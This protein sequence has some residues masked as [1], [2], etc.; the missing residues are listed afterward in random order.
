VESLP[1]KCAVGVFTFT[2]NS[3]AEA[4]TCAQNQFPAGSFVLGSGG[5][6]FSY[7]VYCPDGLGGCHPCRQYT[8]VIALTASDAQSCVQSQNGGCTVVNSCQSCAAGLT[9]CCGTCKNLND[10]QSCGSCTN[11]CGSGQVCCSGT[12]ADLK[13]DPK[14]CGG[15]GQLCDAAWLSCQNGTCGCASGY[16]NCGSGFCMPSGSTCCDP[17]KGTYCAQGES[18][19]SGSCMPSGNVCCGTYNCPGGTACCGGGC[20]PA[21]TACCGTYYCPTGVCCT[22]SSTGCC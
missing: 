8:N 7:A 14:N 12:C 2:A 20:I 11:A 4:T 1:S 19:C 21:G 10:A 3:L 5:G 13:T 6:N 16:T 17:A 9:D 18:C 22:T 15:C